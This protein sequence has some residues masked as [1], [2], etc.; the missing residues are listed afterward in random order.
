MALLERAE[1]TAL[2]QTEPVALTLHPAAVYLGTLSEGSE[3]AMRS[4]LDAIAKVL[5]DGE[6]DCLT[7]DW[8][9]LRYRHTVAVRTA[10]KQRIGAISTDFT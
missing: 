6:C 5:T 3:R 1:I 2:K 8:S 4:S 7:L 10:L 9:K